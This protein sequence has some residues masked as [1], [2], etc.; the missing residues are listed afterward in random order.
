LLEPDPL[1][2]LEEPELSLNAA[3][4]RRLPRLM[5]RLQKQVQK[6]L[7]ISTHSF[8][9]LTDRGIGPEEVL[10][11]TP[12]PEGTRVEISASLG[13]IKDLLNGGLTLADILQPRMSP[14]N[15]SQIELFE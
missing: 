13:Q 6:Q 11:L 2:L 4:V 12:T 1:L 15:L 8:E 5:Y 10:L 7:I 9:M 14:D 3:I